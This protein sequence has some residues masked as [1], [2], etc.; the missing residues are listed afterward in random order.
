M[1]HVN[2]PAPSPRKLNPRLPPE[3]D[4]AI[5]RLL[6]KDPKQRFQSCRELAEHLGSIRD[7]YCA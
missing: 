2:T 6:S 7:K 4:A 3:L 1:M 5:L